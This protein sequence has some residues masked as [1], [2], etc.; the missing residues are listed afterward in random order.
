MKKYESLHVEGKRERLEY[1]L[2]DNKKD[3]RPGSLKRDRMTRCGMLVL[4]LSCASSLLIGTAIGVHIVYTKSLGYLKA[5][6]VSSSGQLFD[7][8]FLVVGDFG[9]GGTL[10]S[11]GDFGTAKEI[12]ERIAKEMAYVGVVLQPDFVVSTGDN[13]YGGMK[14]KADPAYNETFLSVYQGYPSLSQV[15][16]Y[17]VLGEQDYGSRNDKADGMAES[18]PLYQMTA[19]NEENLAKNWVCCGGR[20]ESF[21]VKQHKSLDLYFL[22]T[23][24]FIHKYLNKPW[25]SYPGGILSEQSKLQAQLDMLESHLEQSTAPWK[26]VVGHHPILSNGVN[27]NTAE[28]QQLRSIFKR[29]KVNLYLNGHDLVLQDIEEDKKSGLHYVTSGSG[30][31]PQDLQTGLCCN[32]A[33]FFEAVPGF[34]TVSVAQHE[35]RVQFWGEK[36]KLLHEYELKRS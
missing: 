6:P 21:S 19:L 30:A 32:K 31:L 20:R 8:K 11:S 34:V 2:L 27:G 15:N 13:I 33:K 26:V 29:H 14:D 23:S 17:S 18:S 4:L 10:Q 28:L 22:D 12:Q 16:W 5:R 36:A 7:T 35:V 9:M 24:P 25:A 1:D 3:L